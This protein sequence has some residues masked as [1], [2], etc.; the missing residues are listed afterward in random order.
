MRSDPPQPAGPEELVPTGPLESF[1][2]ARS[3]GAGP[4]S[5]RQIGEGRSNLTFVLERGPQTFVLRRPPPGPIP[6]GAHDVLRE[7]RVIGALRGT[8]VPVPEVVAT[9]ADTA[10]LGFPF[11]LTGW[12]DGLVVSARMPSSLTTPEAGR[13]LG[14]AVIDSLAAVHGIDPAAVGLA[15]LG[16]PDGYLERQINRHLKLWETYRSRD[17]PLVEEIGQRLYRTLPAGGRQGLVHG[18]Y[19]LANLMF[20]HGS[21]P[22]VASVLDWE[23]STLGDP[24]VDLGYL[25]ACWTEADDPADRPWQPDPATR[26]LPGVS[27]DDLVAHYEAATGTDV[28]SIGWYVALALWRGVIFMEGN[29]RRARDGFIDDP[30]LLEFGELIPRIAEMAHEASLGAG[31]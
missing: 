18:D 26:M 22:R 1:L 17:I 3:L 2:D 23:L 10:V 7:A 15:D 24:L 8:D 19:R 4:I 14:V 28:E 12:I 6:A 21:P 29:Y 11:A 27:R 13:P 31:S 25:C 9:C 16:S 30:Y 20:G 5:L